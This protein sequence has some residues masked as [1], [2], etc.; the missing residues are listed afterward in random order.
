[1]VNVIRSVPAAVV[2]RATFLDGCEKRGINGNT[3]NVYTSYSPIIEHLGLDLWT[4][5][6][7]QVDPAAVKVIQDM[8]ALKPRQ[9]RV[10]NHGWTDDG[11]LWIAARLPSAKNFVVGIPGSTKRFLAGQSFD[12]FTENGT[13]CGTIR[14]S[15]EATS[16]G[17]SPFLTRS[18]ADEDDILLVRFNLPKKSARLSLADDEFLEIV[19]PD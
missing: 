18:G 12:A 2:D 11:E 4:L 8:N 9:K 1:M 6:G 16:W 15:D 3:F 14:N 10:L 19:S 5:R 13:P 17:Y 7:T